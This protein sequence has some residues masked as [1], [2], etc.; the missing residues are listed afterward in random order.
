M[1]AQEIIEQIKALPEEER[2]QVQAY[3]SETKA[4]ARPTW[5][6]QRLERPGSTRRWKM[7]SPNT[8]ELFR[9]LAE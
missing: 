3:L 6:L 5:T 7:F 1:S 2:R 9:K 4:R 8:N